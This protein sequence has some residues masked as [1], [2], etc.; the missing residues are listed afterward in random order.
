MITYDQLCKCYDMERVEEVFKNRDVL[1]VKT[2]RKKKPLG[3]ALNYNN[4]VVK[5][6]KDL[7]FRLNSP[8]MFIQDL[9]KVV[10][11]LFTYYRAQSNLA[12]NIEAFSL[13]NARQEGN[14][15]M[16]DQVIVMEYFGHDLLR[17]VQSQNKYTEENLDKLLRFLIRVLRMFNQR[18]IIHGDLKPANIVR[19][20]N[21]NFKLI[22]FD[23][24]GFYRGDDATTFRGH[25]RLYASQQ[26]LRKSEF[27]KV[28]AEEWRINDLHC[29]AITLLQVTLGL[30]VD[31]LVKIRQD[32]AEGRSTLREMLLDLLPVQFPNIGKRV[33]GIVER[34]IAGEDIEKIARFYDSEVHTTNPGSLIAH[35]NFR[36]IHNIAQEDKVCTI[37]KTK[38]PPIVADIFTSLV[39]HTDLSVIANKL[40]RLEAKDLLFTQAQSNPS[41]IDKVL[42]LCRSDS[43][44]TTIEVNLGGQ[45]GNSAVVSP[46]QKLDFI[47]AGKRDTFSNEIISQISQIGTQTKRTIVSVDWRDY[48]GDINEDCKSVFES[49]E[50]VN[51]LSYLELDLSGTNIADEGFASLSRLL[52]DG[53]NLTQ[54]K[55]NARRCARL[56]ND[57][58]ILL[59]NGIRGLIS[60]TQLNLNITDNSQISDSQTAKVINSFGALSC[61]DSG[62]LI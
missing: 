21:F 2:V 34:F 53:R 46:I 19:D 41:F 11:G 60:L 39:K 32:E 38:L 54:L 33:K 50:Q 28:T 14:K 45:S 27:D 10:T 5:R 48:L 36:I 58:L 9:N 57:S 1:V 42:G 43:R 20:D 35:E 15:M 40:S 30:S 23:N 6:V 44:Q 29:A 18:G 13:T 16:M 37:A 62:I 26:I 51:S 59:A 8:E 31:Q 49:L 7:R 3:E 47:G 12:V 25:T 55:L 22:D 61:S 24:A 17:D 52:Q 56:D 4:V